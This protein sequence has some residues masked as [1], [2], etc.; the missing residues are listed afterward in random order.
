MYSLEE[1]HLWNGRR[2][3]HSMK[4]THIETKDG[5]VI[6][7]IHLPIHPIQHSSR[8]ILPNCF[9]SSTDLIPFL[10]T[11]PSSDSLIIIKVVIT[12]NMIKRQGINIDTIVLTGNNYVSRVLWTVVFCKG[13]LFID[14]L[15]HRRPLN[16]IDPLSDPK[17]FHLLILNGYDTIQDLHFSEL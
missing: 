13:A 16:C 11:P 17:R 5:I 2:L 10:F 14:S 12:R 8:E 9:I 1:M 15:L 3:Y 6:L 4:L 7:R